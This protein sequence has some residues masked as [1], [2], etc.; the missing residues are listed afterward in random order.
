MK[1]DR[2]SRLLPFSCEQVFDL[3]A[4]VERYPE[5]LPGWISARI[6]QRESNRL[7]VEQVL[8]IGPVRLRFDSRTVLYRPER[9]EVTSSQPPFRYYSLTWLFVPGPAASCSL[10]VLIDLELQSNLLQ[11]VVRRLLPASIAGAIAAFATPC[12][13][14]VC[15]PR[16]LI[17]NFRTRFGS[18]TRESA[19]PGRVATSTLLPPL[20]LIRAAVAAVWLV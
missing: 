2:I 3:A 17:D 1:I 19:P 5:F 13:P 10:S 14:L 16:W 8:G 18:V 15:K 20:W 7:Y 12:E 6:L 4:D 9:I 11:H